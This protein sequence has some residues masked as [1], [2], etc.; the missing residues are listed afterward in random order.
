MASMFRPKWPNGLKLGFLFLFLSE[1]SKFC[2]FLTIRFGSNNASMW[3]KYV[4]NNIWR[5]L[6]LPVPLF[7]DQVCYHILTLT[8]LFPYIISMLVN[9]EQNRM[10]RNIQNLKNFW[11]KIGNH[12]RKFD[13]NCS[14]LIS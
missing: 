3:S 11:Q 2:T 4:S 14:M 12:L 6:K 5:D 8:L 9:F 10:V 7:S 13:L 1:S